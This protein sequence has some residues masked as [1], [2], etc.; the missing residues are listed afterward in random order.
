MG[1][2]PEWSGARIQDEVLMPWMLRRFAPQ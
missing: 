2:S 1:R